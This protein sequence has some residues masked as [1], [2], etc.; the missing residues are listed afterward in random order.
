MSVINMK[1]ILIIDDDPYVRRLY[2]HLFNHSKYQIELSEDGFDGY[3]KAKASVP[4]LILLDIMMP[5][6]NGLELL[7]KL[8][9]E[10]LTK[11]VPIIMLTNVCDQESA[12]TAAELG[13]TGF[14]VK[15]QLEPEKLKEVVDTYLNSND[16]S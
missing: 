15:S 3:E 12:Q 8:K 6:M 14:I 11:D 13:A 9:Q 10:P 7:K 16:K 2:G 1:K 5:K 4:N